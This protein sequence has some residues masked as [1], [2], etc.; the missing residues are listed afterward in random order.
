MTNTVPSKT[1]TLRLVLPVRA[2]LRTPALHRW[3]TVLFALFAGYPL[4]AGW[5]IS[6]QIEPVST[7]SD[8]TIGSA[9]LAALSHDLR[10]LDWPFVAYFGAA[11][12]VAMWLVV[13]PRITLMPVAIVAVIAL[14]TQGPVAIWLETTLHAQ[15]DNLFSAIVAI[16]GSEELAKI[17]PLVAALALV[18]KLYPAR[19]GEILDLSPRAFLYLGC[20]SGV[21]FGC[22][23]A[24]VYIVNTQN[25]IIAGQG[26]VLGL[27]EVVFL[28]LITDPINHAL[29]AGITGFFVGLAVLRARRL[30]KL[31]VSGLV[32]QS[33]LIAIGLAVAATLHGLHD[34]A[35]NSALQALIDTASALLL[36]GYAVAGDIVERAIATAPAP[37][38]G[39]R[40]AE[41]ARRA[42]ADRPQQPP[43]GAPYLYPQ[44]YSQ[45]PQYAPVPQ[46]P[47]APAGPPASWQPPVPAWAPAPPASAAPAPAWT[48]PT[49]PP[50]QR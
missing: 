44:P 32:E 8:G 22:S 40:I 2:W 34:F 47:P 3:G 37:Q 43:P 49:R 9:G 10:W 5:V 18:A 48:G 7:N 45:T 38:W 21:V 28:R 17:I 12:L 39:S 23:E 15:T 41:A 42:A 11:W 35:G 1:S 46:Y 27:T 16:G 29:W 13:R 6:K 24:V 20:V 50:A 26:S 14:I 25:S 36:L 31:T 33:W 4:L 19:Q 30:N